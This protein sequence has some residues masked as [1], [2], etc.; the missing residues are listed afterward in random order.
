MTRIYVPILEYHDLSEQKHTEENFHSPYIMHV[1]KFY[2]QMGWLYKNGYSSITIDDLLKN[3][4]SEKSVILTFDDGH[5]SNYDLAFPILKEFNFTA[6]F[7]VL[8]NSINNKNF[9]SSSQLIEMQ[10]NNMKIESHSLTHSY[11]ITLSEKDIK[12]EVEGSKQKLQDIIK[13]E[14]KHF[15]VPYGFYNRLLIQC[16]REAGYKSLVTENFG[17]YSYQNKPFYLL[18]RFTIKSNIEL[19]LF[20]NIAARKKRR[21]VSMYLKEFVLNSMKK[22][23][24]YKKYILLKLLIIGEK[25]KPFIKNM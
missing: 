14:V 1:S 9:L 6:T 25:P 21:L 3:N 20:K 4:I 7:F 11:I 23:L 13:T 24:G 8:L 17:Y 18:P 10:G 15:S 16:L 5:I 19:N 22:I 12:K 2:E